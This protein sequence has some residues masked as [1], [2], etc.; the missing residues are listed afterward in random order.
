MLAREEALRII[1]FHFSEKYEGRSEELRREVAEVF[2][3]QEE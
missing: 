3:G 1:P 2:E